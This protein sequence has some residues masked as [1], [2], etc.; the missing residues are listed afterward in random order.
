VV[1]LLNDPDYKKDPAGTM[2]QQ[3]KRNLRGPWDGEVNNSPQYFP[4]GKPQFSE[5]DRHPRPAGD[6]AEPGAWQPTVVAAAGLNVRQYVDWQ[7]DPDTRAARYLYV[8]ASE[9]SAGAGEIV[10]LAS[11]RQ[12]SMNVGQWR[13]AHPIQDIANP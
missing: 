10:D 2:L 6:G 12:R 8:T 11:T 3:L 13:N 5:T 7:S 9:F 1:L 4:V